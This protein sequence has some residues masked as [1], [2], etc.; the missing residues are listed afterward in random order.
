MS[1]TTPTHIIK[2][3]PQKINLLILP[4]CLPLEARVSRST[5]QR[6]TFPPPPMCGF[7]FENCRQSSKSFHA[8]GDKSL[9]PMGDK[10]LF[11]SLTLCLSVDWIVCVNFSHQADPFCSLCLPSCPFLS[12]HHYASFSP[13]PRV[14][15]FPLA[16]PYVEFFST[17][18]RPQRNFA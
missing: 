6:Y 9:F 4:L 2:N 12:T 13:F 8:M 16:A 10:L 1:S 3:I 15:L 11:R 18:V 7:F 14:P 17:L 5:S